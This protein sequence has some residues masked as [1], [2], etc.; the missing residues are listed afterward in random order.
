MY[1]KFFIEH[2]TKNYALWRKKNGILSN[3]DKINIQKRISRFSSY[4]L[5]SFY[6]FGNIHEFFWNESINSLITQIYPNWDLHICLTSNDLDLNF[7]ISQFFEINDSRISFSMLKNSDISFNYGRSFFESYFKPFLKKAKGDY[8]IFM[9]PGVLLSEE[10]LF[11]MALE[12]LQWPDLSMIYTDHDYID[13]QDVHHSPSFK[14]DWSPE[15]FYSFDYIGDSVAFRKDKLLEQGGFENFKGKEIDKILIDL[16]KGL[17]SKLDPASIHHIPRVLFHYKL[18]PEQFYSKQN[19][20]FFNIFCK[21][22]NLNFPI[23][24]IKYNRES[25]Q[26]STLDNYPKVSIIIPSTL[27][28][29]LLKPCIDSILER[30][31]YPIFEIMIVISE[32][33]IFDKRK[34]EYLKK[35]S[36]N[37]RIKVLTYPEKPFNYSYVNNLGVFHSQGEILCLLNDDTEVISQNW[38][39]EMVSW[40]IKKDIGPVGAKLYYPDRRIQHAGIIL[41]PKGELHAFRF[42]NE[43]SVSNVRLF[44]YQNYSAVTG[45]CLVVRKELYLRVNGLDEDAFPI[46]FNDLDLC[47]KLREI[48]FRTLWTPYAQLIHKES[49]SRGHDDSQEKEQRY[50]KELKIFQQRWKPYL[51]DDPSYNPNL[52]LILEDFSLA[53]KPR[54]RALLFTYGNE[55]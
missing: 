4:P 7:K 5:F 33:H 16:K 19:K 50:K 29:E 28:P 30:T 41:V 10:S 25:S 54:K 22:K 51:D 26:S 37:P 18:V 45:A 38:L 6:L 39:S 15:F 42:A 23:K 32:I 12:I 34:V 49:V 27:R 8:I 20:K 47:L 21:N 24:T 14:P 43:Q 1:F 46:S 52:S 48:G 53:P 13:D 17:I 11:N 3:I 35:I 36:N 44:S 40:A 2:G 31:D 9:R 55:Q